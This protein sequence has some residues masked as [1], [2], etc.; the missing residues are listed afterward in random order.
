MTSQAFS[1]SPISNLQAD[2]DSIVSQEHSLKV[3]LGQINRRS[4]AKQVFFAWPNIEE[5]CKKFARIVTHQYPY[6]SELNLLQHTLQQAFSAYESA[7]EDSQNE[8]APMAAFLKELMICGAGT[9]NHSV[10]GVLLDGKTIEWRPFEMPL[11]DW[12]R[13]T[14]VTR[15]IFTPVR[16]EPSQEEIRGARILLASQ[17]LS[18]DDIVFIESHP[19]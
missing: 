11:V 8:S 17:V 6:D 7:A 13:K 12:V 15:L 1:T 19:Q 16:K 18:F 14:K 5:A 10:Y 4:A 9:I 3:A 2:S